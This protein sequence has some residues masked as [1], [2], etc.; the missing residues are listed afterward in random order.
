MC[1]ASAPVPGR[2]VPGG[3]HRLG[4]AARACVGAAL[5]WVGAAHAQTL[6]EF[7]RAAAAADPQAAGVR[8]QYE[9]SQHR[10]DQAKAA[11]GLTA[12]LTFNGSHSQY[13]EPTSAVSPELRTFDSRHARPLPLGGSRHRRQ[14]R[15][16]A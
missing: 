3:C 4:R 13:V 8:A 10:T 9:V 15:H 16:R 14:R 5:C 2:S 7:Y 12:N 6:L 11:F 1:L